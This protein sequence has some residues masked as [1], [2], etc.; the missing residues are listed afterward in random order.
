MVANL[1]EEYQK[2][3]CPLCGEPLEEGSLQCKNCGCAVPQETVEALKRLMRVLR[4]GPQKAMAL[5]EFGYKDPDQLKDKDIEDLLAIRNR[6]RSEVIYLCSECG[7]FVG[8]EEEICSK[9]GTKIGGEAE[10]VEDYIFKEEEKEEEYLCT[11]CGALVSFRADA[12]PYCGRNISGI[13]EEAE[14]IPLIS[15][16]TWMCSECGAIAEEDSKQCD[17]CGT[18]LTPERRI[19]VADVS[20]LGQKEQV[21]FCRNCGAIFAPDTKICPICLEEPTKE[22]M[23][24]DRILKQLGSEELE[25]RIENPKPADKVL[26]KGGGARISG[27]RGKAYPVKIPLQDRSNKVRPEAPRKSFG[28]IER[29][30]EYVVYASLAALVVE[31]IFG[32]VAPIGYEWGIFFLFGVIFG[33]GAGLFASTLNHFKP[34]CK[35]SL[36]LLFG[37]LLILVVPIHWYAGISLE[38]IFDLSI[39]TVG[40]SIFTI[41]ALRAGRMEN[42]SVWML[43]ISLLFLLSL[44]RILGVNSGQQFV[45]LVLWILGAALILTSFSIFLYRKW[46]RLSFDARILRGDESYLAGDYKESIRAYDE[47]ISLSSSLKDVAWNRDMPWYSKGA[48]LVLLGRYEEAIKCIDTAL[49]INPRNEVAWVN[50]GNAVWRLGKGMDA[51]RC[52]NF[53]LKINPRYEVA[54]NNK[55]NILARLGKYEEALKCY[56]KA[57]SI[58]ANYRDALVNKGY[59][60]AKIGNYDEAA[61]CADLIFGQR[62][63]ID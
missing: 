37:S 63:G 33:L 11:Q 16:S 19:G 41:G 54:W 14:G 17:I 27:K 7:A 10:L 29:G 61:K 62:G 31:Y 59:I 49:K 20:T 3:P 43:G 46:L 45:N 32:Q 34:G 39:L 36:S 8:G 23:D 24:V 5:Y 40:L 57:L 44:N 51:L 18:P 26:D 52:Y 38:A 35:R 2:V 47:A 53:A 56:E 28:E 12:C 58:D 4:I 55:G 25:E 15:G 6:G 22:G 13:G 60:L 42:F 48:A 9:C 1:G 21:E 30:R 50:K